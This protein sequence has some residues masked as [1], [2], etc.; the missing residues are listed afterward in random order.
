MVRCLSMARMFPASLDSSEIRSRVEPALYELLRAA[1]SSEF[2]VVH[3]ARWY[4]PYGAANSTGG[5]GEADFVIF[6]PRLGILVI[7]AKSG[8][9]RYSADSGKWI[10]DGGTGA[11][12]RSRRSPLEQA[13]ANRHALELALQRAFPEMPR[14][15]FGFAVAMPECSYDSALE[16]IGLPR[17]LFL[18]SQACGNV[19][20]WVK[21]AYSHFGTEGECISNF[22]VDLFVDLVAGSVNFSSSL[23]SHFALTERTIESLTEEQYKIINFLRSHRRVAISGC[24]G[25]GKTLVAAEKAIRLDHAGLSTLILCH[26]PFLADYLRALTAN[27]VRTEYFAQWISRLLNDTSRSDAPWTHFEE[28]IEGDVARAFDALVTSTERYDAIIVDEGQD[29][30]EEW[31]ILVQAALVHEQFGIMYVFYDDNQALLPFRSKYPI[32]QAPFSLSRNCR[33]AGAI[34]ELVRRFHP[35]AP[36]TSLELQGRGI[37]KQVPCLPGEELAAIHT[38]VR[39]SI[40]MFSSSDLVVLTTEPDPVRESALSDLEVEIAPAWNWQDALMPHLQQIAGYFGHHGDATSSI[41]SV[42]PPLLSDSSYPTGEDIRSVSSFARRLAGNMARAFGASRR[43]GGPKHPARSVK[44]RVGNNGLQLHSQGLQLP[45]SIGLPSI[46]LFLESEGWAEGI[47]KPK[48]I[49]LAPS[50]HCLA[51]DLIRLSTVSSFKGLESPG[52]I[53]FVPPRGEINETDVYVGIS[54]ARLFLCLVGE[55]DWLARIS[56][57]RSQEFSSR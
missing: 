35:Q 29:F 55:S 2:T 57:R 53:L 56:T 10:L 49:R 42:E 43:V 1:L 22:V 41:P 11:P 27:T 5:N 20:A 50:N 30:R 13:E 15:R 14:L 39:M 7:E 19:D 45:P 32:E 31:W 33:N 8:S 17:A 26:N 36:E 34:F 48:Q 52:V 21:G 24:A 44:W 37:V 38:A 47:P 18:D 40:D 16:L 25:S 12:R 6:H 51:K 46:V 3:G 4:L 28:P 23:T 54:R 9:L